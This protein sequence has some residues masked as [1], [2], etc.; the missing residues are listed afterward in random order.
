MNIGFVST[1]LAGTDGVT[2]ETRKWAQVCRKLGHNVSFC[3]GQLDPEMQPSKLVP[4]AHFAHP[5]IVEIQQKCFGVRT[6][7]PETT[8]HIHTIR[9]KLKQEIAEFVRQFSIDVLVP[10]NAL[11]IPMNLPLG[12]ALTEFIAETGIHTIAHHHDFY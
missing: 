2:L 3:A 11:T 1:R 5:E 12:H 10:Q 9:R 7:S 8:E 6:R 4:E